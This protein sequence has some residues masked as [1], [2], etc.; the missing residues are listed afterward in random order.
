M[1]NELEAILFLK[2]KDISMK[3]L[4]NF[5]ELDIEDM[6]R[7]LFQ[8]K[9]LRKDNGINVKIENEKVSLVTNPNCGEAVYRYFNPEVKPKKLSRAAFETLTIIAY[10]GPIT[11]SE[12]EKIRGVNVDGVVS[13]LHEKKLV[14]VVGKAEKIGNPNLYEV[15]E[16]FCAYLNINS[17]EELPN[18]RE[19]REKI[20]ENQEN[21]NNKDGEEIGKN[22]N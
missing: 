20:K 14:K 11:K 13:S 21:K 6:K 3:E 7:A 4:A 16:D 2:A 12:I 5:F 1:L 18:Y 9:E 10:N 17:L 8:L 19:I 15:T 22:K